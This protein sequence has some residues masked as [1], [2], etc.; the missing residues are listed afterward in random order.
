MYIDFLLFVSVTWSL[1]AWGQRIE[2]D[3]N[4]SLLDTEAPGLV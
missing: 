4:R 2:R 1:Y 3:K